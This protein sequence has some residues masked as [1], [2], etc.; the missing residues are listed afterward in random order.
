MILTSSLRGLPILASGRADS[1]MVTEP[2]SGTMEPGTSVN[3]E[4]IKRTVKANSYMSTEMCMRVSG[5]MIRRTELVFTSMSMVLCMM[6]NGAM[7]SNMGR[8]SRLGLI[9]AG[10]RVSMNMEESTVWAP[11]SGVMARCTRVIGVRT[12]SVDL[13][14]INGWMVADTKAN[15]LKIIW[16]GSEFTNGAMAESITDNTEKTRNTDTVFILGRMGVAMKAT[17]TKESNMV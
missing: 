5:P 16:K 9:I 3:G 4:I 12:K 11:I 13:A 14:F 17:G 1:V 10:M 15:G 7:I 6:G 2:R 8:E